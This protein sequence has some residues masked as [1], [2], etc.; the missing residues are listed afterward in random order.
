[1]SGRGGLAR[2]RITRSIIRAIVV[3]LKMAADEKFYNFM[4]TSNL[5]WAEIIQQFS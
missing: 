4:I 1:M 2:V 3:I 5:L